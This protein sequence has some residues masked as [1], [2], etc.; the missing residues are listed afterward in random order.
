ML[1]PHQKEHLISFILLVFLFCFFYWIFFA[2]ETSNRSDTSLKKDFTES[3]MI[4]GY[5]RIIDGDTIDINKNR[6][7]L[8]GIDAPEKKQ[9]CLSK[10]NDEYLCGE[11]STKFLKELTH[12]KKV[13]CFYGEKDIYNRYLGDCRVG[14]IQISNEM[15]KNG[16][17]IIYNLKDADEGLKDLEKYAKN[18]QI[19]V[20][21]GAFEEP[22]QYRKKNKQK[23]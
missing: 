19:G 9:R 12:G 8:A 23:N 6:I 18:K 7:R 20:W 5:A 21:Q 14:E 10:H 15:V 17:A 22:K 16:M 2:S 3:E 11:T 13:E 1:K 4:S